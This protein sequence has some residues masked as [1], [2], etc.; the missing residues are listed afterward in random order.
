MEWNSIDTIDQAKNGREI[1]VAYG[2]QSGTPVK[3]VFY[4]KVHKHW[5]HYGEAE[6]G[7]ERNATH[8]ANISKP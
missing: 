8:W 3:V 4:N 2:R 6:L 5:S 1:L 7:L